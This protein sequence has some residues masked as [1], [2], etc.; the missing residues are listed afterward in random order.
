[1]RIL[2]TLT[3]GLLTVSSGSFLTAAPA[4]P[5][6]P[7]TTEAPAPAGAVPRLLAL[8]P[9]ADG[10]VRVQV[11]RTEQKGVNVVIGGGG[12]APRQQTINVTVR[13]EVELGDVKD[14]TITTAGGK[15]VS[16]EDAI[17]RLA[18]GGVVAVSGDGKPVD[19]GYLALFKD[20]LLVLTSPELVTTLA[21][22]SVGFTA[23]GGVAMPAPAIAP[24][25]ILLPAQAVPAPILLPA[26]AVPVPVAPAKEAPAPMKDK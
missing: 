16:K 25:P 17:K 8:R 15:T 6:A 13:A 10:K 22:S 24:A 19:P 11:L 2:A 4:L 1:M 12:G 5:P 18:A 21:K 23:V 9:G 7:K 20:N 14:L 3:A 26:Q